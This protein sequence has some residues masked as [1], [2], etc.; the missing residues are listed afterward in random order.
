MKEGSDIALV[1]DAGT[2][3]ISDPGYKIVKL[4]IKNGISVITVPGASSVISALT[5][6]G[7]STNS[8]SFFGFIPR[9][10]QHINS[11]IEDIK[12][13]KSTLI[14]FESPNRIKKT[15]KIFQEALGNRNAALCRE[16]TK[17]HEEII[18]GT[19]EEIR[20][21]INLKEGIKGEICLVI[22]GFK[23]DSK[24]KSNNE[25]TLVD[26][27]LKSLKKLKISLKDAVKVVSQEF[28]LQKKEI[29]QKALKIWDN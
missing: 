19:I 7:L 2:P 23:G 3:C 26:N 24:N 29:Y 20:E 6:S 15:L 5:L 28:N 9:T 25:S 21:N 4:A 22:E 11:L 18:H 17:L 1:T 8:F 14:F 13:L 16:L 10:S 27:R 12:F